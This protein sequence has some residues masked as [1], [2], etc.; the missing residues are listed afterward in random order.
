LRNSVPEDFDKSP[1]TSI[2]QALVDRVG[3]AL[4]SLPEG[5]KPIKQIE[6]LLKDRKTAFFSD[7]QLG[8]AEAELLAFGSLLAEKYIVR[9]SGQDVKRG[10]FSHRHAYFWDVNTNQSYS[11]LNHIDPSQAKLHLYNSLLSEFGVMG[12]EYGYAMATPHALVLWEA[13]F[14]DFVNGAQVM[15][16]QFITSSESKWQRQNGLVLLLPHGYEGQGPEHSSAKPERFLQ[17]AAEFNIVVAN[18]TSA[19][20]YFHLLRRQV[21]WE[22][23]KPCVVFS[24]KSLLRH[25]GVSSPVTDF[26]SG[27]FIEILDDPN[28]SAKDVKRVVLCTGKIFFE[29]QEVQLKKKIKNTALIRI[30]QLYPFPKHQFQAVLTKYKSAELI[31]AQEE[32]Y[33]MGYWSY[34]QRFLPEHQ[35]KVVARKSSASPATGYSKVH[36]AEQ[37]KIINLAFDI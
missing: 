1:D 5:F 23:R 15:I 21:K 24:P 20:N 29:L 22:F 37:E 19:S 4:T 2:P 31:W 32:P 17:L 27:S 7:K 34:I 18:I 6:K 30:E 13:Q 28:A 11:G 8:W 16:D 25:P 9:M 33:N 3:T 14:G 26:T 36:K 35:L 10:T 12:F